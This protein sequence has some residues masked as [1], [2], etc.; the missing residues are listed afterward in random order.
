MSQNAGAVRQQIEST[1][2]ER[3]MTDI[4]YKKVLQTLARRK[5]MPFLELTSVCDISEE[6]LSRIIKDLEFEDVIRVINSDDITE[7]IITLKH[8]GFGIASV[9]AY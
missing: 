6:E 3:I 5:S 7:E 4:T 2:P 1:L 9:L 8:K